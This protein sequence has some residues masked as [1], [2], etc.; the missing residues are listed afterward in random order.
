MAHLMGRTLTA[1]T[2]ESLRPGLKMQ[3][4]PDPAT[5]GLE[6]YVTPGGAKTF[7]LRYTLRDGT[8]R[9]MNLGRWP[10]MTYADARAAALGHMN[11]V[12]LGGDPALLRKQSVAALRSRTVRTLSDL[13]NAL[14]EASEATGVRATTLTYW[15]WL[16]KKHIAPRLGDM[17]LTDVGA[18][19]VRRVLRE[20]G[21]QA[22]PTTANR[23]FGLLRRAFNFGVEEEHQPASP[24]AGMKPLFDEASR[25]RVLSDDQLK[26]LWTAAESARQ[27]PRAGDRRRDDLYVSRSLAIA[28]QLCLVTA[29]RG[30]EVIG[31]R[32]DEL[33]LAE[34]TW[35]LPPHRTKANREHVVPLSDLAVSLVAEA[36]ELAAAR[37]GRAPEN[38]DPI[39][40]TPR[41]GDVQRNEAG[42]AVGVVK[43]VARL[44]LGR[45][46]SRLCE[47][48]N[49]TDA[50]AHDLRRTA[51]TLMASDRLGVLTEV[52]ARIL[53][54]APPGLGV[55]A[56]YNRHRYLAEKR[57]ALDAWERLLLAIVTGTEP[58]NNVVQLATS[59]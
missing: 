27:A 48:A 52:I 41:I 16:D 19:S 9:R 15:R 21:V 31:L 12:E 34:R 59:R 51:S 17:R 56:V 24:I 42:E 8:R 25:T 47:A 49:V 39:F 57:R 36:R 26:A 54:H 5:P 3:A 43:S 32:A 33:D 13:M 46:M 18:G 53:N 55:T 40:P 50:G 1:K 44:S 6:V 35:T 7:S 23:A 30:G 10:A 2:I 37:L 4:F 38:A 20:I 22:G 28:V 29:Q 45:A 11:S 14:F 58:A